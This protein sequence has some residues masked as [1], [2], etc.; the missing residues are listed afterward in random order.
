MISLSRSRR[1]STSGRWGF[2][3]ETL[4]RQLFSNLGYEI[5]DEDFDVRCTNPLHRKR[6]HEIDFIT[7]LNSEIFIRSVYSPEGRVLVECKLGEVESADIEEAKNKLE[8]LNRSAEYEDVSGI[9]VA[10]NSK[11]EA[12]IEDNVFCW[13]EKKLFFYASKVFHLA[14]LQKN[15]S[16]IVKEQRLEHYFYTSFITNYEIGSRTAILRVTVF[17]EDEERPLNNS[18]ITEI[19]RKIGEKY[20]EMRDM[21]PDAQVQIDA[22]SLSGFTEDIRVNKAFSY[23]IASWSFLLRI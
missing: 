20:L 3:F 4:V 23:D 19:S 9:I 14:T 1:R 21:F 22:H 17:H 2:E 10:T 12:E 15:A 16:R 5:I 13:D 8:C 7:D 6:S 18:I 11:H